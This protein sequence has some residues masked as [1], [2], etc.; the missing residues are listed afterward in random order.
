MF[1]RNIY[2]FSTEIQQIFQNDRFKKRHSFLFVIISPEIV[3]AISVLV[4]RIITLRFCLQLHFA[5]YYSTWP[6]IN[7]SQT[8]LCVTQF[9]YLYEFY[10]S[11]F[12]IFK[13][14]SY[15]ATGA[16]SASQKCVVKLSRAICVFAMVLDYM[17][18]T[19]CLINRAITVV[20][21]IDRTSLSPVGHIYRQ[22]GIYSNSDASNLVTCG[23]LV[24]N[25]TC[26]C[27]PPSSFP[28]TF[29]RVDDDIS[30]KIFLQRV[31]CSKRVI[32]VIAPLS[33]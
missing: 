15:A 33:K 13:N 23:L 4:F 20:N 32:F 3:K 30:L 28:P 27:Q 7:S 24:A 31:Q 6:T 11:R 26:F 21:S 16:R 5:M 18:N 2:F 9:W 10:G 1:I 22:Q 14:D 25:I 19:R 8:M 29:I 12:K 17:A